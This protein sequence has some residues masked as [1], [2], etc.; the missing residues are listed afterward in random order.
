MV[1]NDD[2]I[3]L[4]KNRKKLKALYSLVAIAKKGSLAHIDGN[5]IKKQRLKKIF[6]NR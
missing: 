1:N 2:S 3:K 4:K 5:H 6:K